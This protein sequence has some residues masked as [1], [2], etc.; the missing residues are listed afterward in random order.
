MHDGAGRIRRISGQRQLDRRQCTPLGVTVAVDERGR[1]GGV[2]RFRY[3][4]QRLNGRVDKSQPD[5]AISFDWSVSRTSLS[6]AAYPRRSASPA[7]ENLPCF[8]CHF[9]RSRGPL[10]LP[11]WKRHLPFGIANWP[12]GCPARVFAPHR[13]ISLWGIPRHL[14]ITPAPFLDI[15]DDGLAAFAH[16]DVLNRDGA[17]TGIPIAL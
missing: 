15:A 13:A 9:E 12:H 7:F 16:G 11:P 6:R 1:G 3:R 8:R 14:P 4:L 10:D 5:P 2:A 17:L